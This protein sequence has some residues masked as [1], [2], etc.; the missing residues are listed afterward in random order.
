MQSSRKAYE[1]ISNALVVRDP[2]VIQ[3]TPPCAETL[4]MEAEHWNTNASLLWLWLDG[5][6][7]PPRC[8]A[9]LGNG[10]VQCLECT[11][12][13]WNYCDKFH[14]CLSRMRAEP[15]QELRN[16]SSVPYCDQH[17][18]DASYTTKEPCAYERTQHSSFCEDHSCPCCVLL[19]SSSSEILVGAKMPFSCAIHKCVLCPSAQL[20]P[21]KFCASHLCEECGVSGNITNSPKVAY[22]KYCTNH[23]C[24]FEACL[25][26]RNSV[27]SNGN[28]SLYCSAHSCILCRQIGKSTSVVFESRYCKDHVC[29]HVD[30]NTICVKRRMECSMYCISHTCRICSATD[31]FPPLGPVREPKPRNVCMEHP[32]CSKVFRH[33]GLCTEVAIPPLLMYC[34]DHT[35]TVKKKE[36]LKGKAN[37]VLRG[38]G[39]CHGIAKTTKQRC[40]AKGS[41]ADG[42]R[43]WCDAHLI[44]KKLQIEKEKAELSDDEDEDEDIVADLK[45]PATD[46]DDA[47]LSDMSDEDDGGVSNPARN[48]TEFFLKR[49][50]AENNGHSCQVQKWTESNY[51]YEPWFCWIRTNHEGEHERSMIYSDVS[52]SVFADTNATLHE[53]A[54]EPDA[55]KINLNISVLQLMEAV[56]I[57]EGNIS[58]FFLIY[59][60]LIEFCWT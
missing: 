58:I 46:E 28:L 35:Q 4:L 34:V 2:A 60:K 30:D 12:P 19:L 45:E 32:L 55:T 7:P 25:Q 36:E 37:N 8:G 18:C 17:I 11:Q 59:R 53:A 56:A 9:V 33:G 16:H 38:D 10:D 26:K 51:I 3:K 54:S 52:R 31:I 44:Q 49:C 50:C 24:V 29:Q 42:G 57:V 1:F 22:S 47:S 40:K 48:V 6:N 20:F 39:Q 21:H 5:L 13:S 14:R 41:S 27:Q 43:W 23:K 15:C